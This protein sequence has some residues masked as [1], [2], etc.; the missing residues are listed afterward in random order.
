M[1]TQ[2]YNN[3]VRYYA[4]HHFIFYPV[5][6]ILVF[7]CIRSAWLDTTNQGL[8]LMMALLVLLMGWLSWMMRQHYA[9]TCQDRMVRLELRL[10]YYQLTQQRLE[11]IE[12]GLSIEQLAALRFASDDEL[13]E[14]I[15]RALDE[16]LSPTGIKQAIKHWLPDSMRV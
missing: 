14:L 6:V 9:L 12:D 2:Q 3:H 13:V 16:K 15:Q 4:P 1:K 11:S 5:I 10:R 8:W 7:I